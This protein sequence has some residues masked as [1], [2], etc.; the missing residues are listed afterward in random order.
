MS[1]TADT[2]PPEVAP[3]ANPP[4]TIGP[5]SN[6]PA[7][8]SPIRS[9]WPQSVS[10]YITNNV[11][12]KDTA[13]AQTVTSPVTFSSSVTTTGSATANASGGALLAPNG[14]VA[15]GANPPTASAAGVI[16]RSDGVVTST[17]MNPSPANTPNLALQRTGTGP[18]DVGGIF[19]RFNRAN[20]ADVIGTITIATG[21]ASVLYNTTSDRRLKED[22]GLLTDGLARVLDLQPRR[23]AWLT[24]G[25]EFDGFIADEV[26]PVAPYAVTGEPGAVLTADDPANPGGIDPQQLDPSKLIPLL[27]AAVQELAGRLAALEGTP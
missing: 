1:D 3:R 15:V 27:V 13:P 8:G 19:V 5:F 14:N 22:L 10:T 25:S 23:L 11:L 12:R 24:D 26:Q 7:P 21:G 4:T 16:A 18:Q 6:V 2:A 9:D 17:V 20:T